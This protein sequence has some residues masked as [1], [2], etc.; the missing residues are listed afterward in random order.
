MKTRHS[1]I[2]KETVMIMTRRRKAIAASLAMFLLVTTTASAQTDASRIDEL[3]AKAAAMTQ[4]LAELRAEL[5]N[6]KD[7]IIRIYLDTKRP[8][9]FPSRRKQARQV[10][11]CAGS[12]F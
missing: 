7:A 2:L 5:D 4:Q 3:E 6:A 9:C 8:I 1:M 12:C 10:F 11:G